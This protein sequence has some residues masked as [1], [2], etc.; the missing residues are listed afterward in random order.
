M[1]D[2][3]ELAELEQE[4]AQFQRLPADVNDESDIDDEYQI[5]CELHGSDNFV[6]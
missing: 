3:D 2:L 1:G 4:A 5:A 6:A